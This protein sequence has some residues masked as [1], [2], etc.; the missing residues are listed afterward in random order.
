MESA[1]G[2]GVVPIGMMP[3]RGK[4]AAMGI[5]EWEEFFKTGG[6]GGIWGVDCQP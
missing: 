2:E 1:Q 6:F 3:G 4:E 5:P